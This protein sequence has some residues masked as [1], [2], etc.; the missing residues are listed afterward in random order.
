M[1]HFVPTISARKEITNTI[2]NT[3][4]LM[5]NTKKITHQIPNTWSQMTSPLVKLICNPVPI[6][7][8]VTLHSLSS[9]TANYSIKSLQKKSQLMVALVTFCYQTMAKF[10]GAC[11]S[12]V[13]R[14]EMILWT[15]ISKLCFRA[16]ILQLC[17]RDPVTQMVG[18]EH[19]DGVELMMVSL[20]H[21][22]QWGVQK[23][24]KLLLL[25][26]LPWLRPK[27][28]LLLTRLLLKRLLLLKRKQKKLLI[29]NLVLMA[30]VTLC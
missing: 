22:G 10:L 29:I 1:R 16:M 2:L 25:K 9:P 21:T 8:V 18:A 17:L 26:K 3:A 28:R 7:F 24:G 11:K 27:K 6:S 20:L 15:S 12:M 14:S 30:L 4:R 23:L 19:M 13:T 5:V